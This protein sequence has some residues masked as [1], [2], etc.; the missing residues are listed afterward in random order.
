MISEVTGYLLSEDSYVWTKR[1]LLKVNEILKSDWVLGLDLEKR[2]VIFEK[3]KS[4]PIKLKKNR[5]VRITTDV[6]ELVLPE[7]SEVYTAK[8]KNK[9]LNITE[10]VMLDIFYRP[11]IFEMLRD[12]YKY[13]PL[14]SLKITNKKVTITENIAYLLGTQAIIP[15]KSAHKLVLYLKSGLNYAKVCKI[16]KRALTELEIPHRIY[17]RPS[18]YR[19]II[20]FDDSERKILITMISSLF[21]NYDM[22][23]VIRTSP[24][25]VIQQFIEGLLDSRAKISKGRLIKLHIPASLDKI[26]RFIYSSLALFGVQPRY[27]FINKSDRGLKFFALYFALP[28]TRPFELKSLAISSASLAIRTREDIKVYSQVKHIVKLRRQQFIIPRIQ[29]H[30]DIIVDLVP[31]HYQTIRLNC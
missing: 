15:R 29:E 20:I 11:Q 23:K 31:L 17:Y 1:G 28:E 12:L 22:P 18:D 16:L 9:A 19:K 2:R 5:I 7:N 14:T 6:N 8:G 3:I 13:H 21:A 4:E 27:T 24:T 26:R 25:T 30:W 10:G